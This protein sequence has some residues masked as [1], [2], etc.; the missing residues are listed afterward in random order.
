MCKKKFCVYWERYLPFHIIS[1]WSSLCSVVML[2]S[3][4]RWTLHNTLA[5]QI[6]HT[7]RAFDSTFSY[8]T[9][10]PSITQ[11][12]IN[13]STTRL[14]QIGNPCYIR[15]KI[16]LNLWIHWQMFCFRSC[17]ASYLQ[18]SVP[19]KTAG[20]VNT[21]TYGRPIWGH[22]CKQHNTG[23]GH[24]CKQVNNHNR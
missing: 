12:N 1:Y 19:Y 13:Q 14:C 11:Q 4:S 23:W 16:N 22:S 9:D 2:L 3:K 17:L 18:N 5:G 24:S 15:T 8:S 21:W 10:A 7:T 20:G 6:T